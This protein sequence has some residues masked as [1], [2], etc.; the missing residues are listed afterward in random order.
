[1][2]VFGLKGERHREL[3][4]STCRFDAHLLACTALFAS[5]VYV[6]FVTHTKGADGRRLQDEEKAGKLLKQQRRAARRIQKAMSKSICHASQS[7]LN[8][9]TLSI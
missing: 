2:Y 4:L 5:S 3:K 6:V 9:N 1:M 8:L 7:V